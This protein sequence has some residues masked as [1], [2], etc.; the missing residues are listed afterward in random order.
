MS[1]RREQIVIKLPLSMGV[2]GVVMQAIA[3]QY[4]T[5]VV[6]GPERHEHGTSVLVIEVDPDEA[7]P[8]RYE[9]V[10]LVADDRLLSDVNRGL[11]APGG[12][13]LTPT[14]PKEKA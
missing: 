2:A 13:T 14:E 4:P 3:D 8:D 6:L 11:D 12:G 7:D 1:E 9:P 10:P 5:S